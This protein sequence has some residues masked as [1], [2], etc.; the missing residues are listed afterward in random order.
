MSKG[1]YKEFK[2]VIMD[3]IQVYNIWLV[4]NVTDSI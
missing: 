1:E 3:F 4:V 2:V